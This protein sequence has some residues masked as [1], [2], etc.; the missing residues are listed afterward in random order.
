[1]EENKTITSPVKA[2]RAKCLE[3]TCGNL[4]EIKECIITHCPLYPFRFGKNP[5]AKRKYTQEQKEAMAE[6]LRLAR[7]RKQE[8]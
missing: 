6:R 1:M 3:C 5:Y 4:G 7:E 8:A 2:I